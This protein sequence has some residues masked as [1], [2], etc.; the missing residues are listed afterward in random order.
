M[1][2]NWIDFFQGVIDNNR[3]TLSK[4]EEAQDKGKSPMREVIKIISDKLKNDEELTSYEIYVLGTFCNVA[5]ANVK[6]MYERAKYTYDFLQS[7]VCEW[8][9]KNCTSGANPRSLV[10]KF[11]NFT[12]EFPNVEKS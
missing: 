2:K 10:D 8:F 7:P 6:T 5:A 1:N 12:K 3:A 4:V 9:S 11:N